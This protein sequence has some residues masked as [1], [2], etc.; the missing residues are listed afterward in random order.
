M[1]PSAVVTVL[2]AAIK[3]QCPVL[4]TGHPGVGK[5][6]TGN[7]AAALEGFD[8]VTTMPAVEDPT[9]PAGIPW[10]GAG[11]DFARLVP[12]EQL[13]QLQTT[14]KPT[15]WMMDDLGQGSGAVQAAYMQWLLAR[16][17]GAH[18]L[19]DQVSIIALTNHL[20][21]G[22]LHKIL[23]PV[24]GRFVT[25]I[26]MDVDAGD[27]VDWALGGGCDRNGVAIDPRTIAYIRSNPDQLVEADAP[28]P[29]MKGFRSPRG[30]AAVTS[31]HAMN[32]PRNVEAE[33]LC[34]T[35]GDGAG[36]QYAAWLNQ[37]A[38]M[39]SV[40]DILMDPR[41]APLPVGPSQ[42][43]ATVTALA[44]KTT[45]PLV[46]RAAIYIERLAGAGLAEF[47][48]LGIK[49]TKARMSKA[50][51]GGAL[52]ATPEYLRLMNGEIGKMLFPELEEAS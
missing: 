23:E 2:R 25:V 31:V 34:G 20:G 48:A 47:A 51:Q 26:D 38:A 21:R 43:Y 9:V 15:L 7:Q 45:I 24:R 22:A 13:H 44:A 40:D 49:D 3:S 6:D 42:C 14:D 33:C 36:T 30:W 32:L 12:F 41:N 8:V 37:L 19:S 18:K 46:G 39:I 11:D 5:T 50:G 17:C 1:K 27:W 16:R 10:L 28:P 35:I 29:G 4:V 52:E